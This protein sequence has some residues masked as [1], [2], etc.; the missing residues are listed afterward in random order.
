MYCTRDLEFQKVLE[1]RKPGRCMD[2]IAGQPVAWLVPSPRQDQ[3][4]RVARI[5]GPTDQ[6]QTVY[7]RTEQRFLRSQLFQHRD[8]CKCDLC[9]RELP[10]KLLIA[11]HIKPRSE[12][13]S[14]ERLDFAN[15]AFAACLL[16]CDALYERGYISVS[17]S[18]HIVT[19]SVKGLPIPLREQ[20]DAVR[21][22][23]CTAWR[24][25]TFDYFAWHYNRWFFRGL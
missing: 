13:E 7:R 6:L 19:T 3:F 24:Q 5:P 11:A 4:D 23:P 17:H 20:L 21:K 8:R 18:G 2:H 16:G 9:G 1:K 10:E 25:G 22:R 12:C 15:I 14:R